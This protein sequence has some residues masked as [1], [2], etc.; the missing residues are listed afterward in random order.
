MVFGEQHS[1]E[2]ERTRANIELAEA[3][4]D[5]VD[6]LCEDIID[7]S[8]A[9]LQMRLTQDAEAIGLYAAA[10]FPRDVSVPTYVN[11]DFLQPPFYKDE[12]TETLTLLFERQKPI[13]DSLDNATGD[14]VRVYLPISK[15]YVYPA[16]VEANDRPTE[17]YIEII[18]NAKKHEQSTRYIIQPNLSDPKKRYAIYEYNSVA[19]SGEQIVHDEFSATGLR[20]ALINRIPEDIELAS[21]LIRRLGNFDIIYQGDVGLTS[22]E[23]PLN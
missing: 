9:A 2:Q 17:I 12:T 13:D 20:E 7:G 21:Q 19:D 11:P 16:P 22:E 15:H 18:P 1:S 8:F 10:G 3:T 4:R 23:A 14:Q 5:S 6:R